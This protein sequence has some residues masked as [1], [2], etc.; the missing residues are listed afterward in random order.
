MRRRRFLRTAST[1]AAATAT[2]AMPGG[3]AAAEGGTTHTVEM[4]DQLAFDPDSLTIAPGDTV[5]FE[6]VGNAGHSVTA[7]EEDIPDGAD[8][9]ASGGFDSQGAAQDGY[10]PGG[11]VSSGNVPGGESWEHTFETEGVHE[12]FCI[13]HEAGG[14]VGRI[15]VG[16]G[17]ASGDGGDS[18]PIG[19]PG[20]I[21]G[22]LGIGVA[23][24]LSGMYY[25]GKRSG[26][27]RN[28]AALAG[29]GVVALGIV[30]L[31]A[32]VA[33]LLVTG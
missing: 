3:A 15:E 28:T 29:V 24:F 26:E 27:E 18:L 31:I 6:N 1:V 25:G 5:V 14:M 11:D 12:Y 10:E 17:S 9:W 30:L 20:V 4:T 33:S 13:P 19:V 8:Y 7:Y 22:G 16:A 23:S 32:V 2:A 21:F